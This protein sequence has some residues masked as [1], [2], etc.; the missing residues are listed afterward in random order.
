M[1][2]HMQSA[3]RRL[4]CL[5]LLYNNMS[6]FH[7]RGTVGKDQTSTLTLIWLLMLNGMWHKRTIH[8]SGQNSVSLIIITISFKTKISIQV[9][10]C[11]SLYNLTE[12]IIFLSFG[13]IKHFPFLTLLYFAINPLWFRF[14]LYTLNNLFVNRKNI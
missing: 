1:R 11:F 12:N 7:S 14:K 8:Y 10:A 13:Q 4:I 5:A 3:Q 2:Q 9:R 6:A